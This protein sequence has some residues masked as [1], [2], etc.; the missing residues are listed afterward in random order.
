DHPFFRVRLGRAARARADHRAVDPQA[1]SDLE[2]ARHFGGC[3]LD[4]AWPCQLPRTLPAEDHRPGTLGGRLLL[5]RAD[6]GHF[7]W[8]AGQRPLDLAHRPVPQGD[9][10]W[11]CRMR[12]DVPAARLPTG[13]RKSTRL[14]TSHVK[15][16]YA[17]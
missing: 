14:N 13:D 7:S 5:H 15:I 12:G 16:S 4:C 6:A 2:T 10:P 11:P 17:V 9:V 3:R 1:Q 8:V